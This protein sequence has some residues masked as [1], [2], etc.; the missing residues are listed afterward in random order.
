MSVDPQSYMI[1]NDTQIK[2]FFGPYRWM[3]NFHEC[4]VQF[5]GDI[6]PSSEHAYQAAKYDSKQRTPFFAGTMQI[7][8]VRSKKLGA[9]AELD[10][11][12]WDERRL[13]VM[14][15]IVFSKFL[16]HLHLR[17]QLKATKGKYLEETNHWGDCYWGVCDGIGDNML[18][19][20]LMATR[21]YFLQMEE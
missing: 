16:L 21:A 20:I 14:Q 3:S 1:H 7:S 2:G 5:E 12:E 15:D 10:P 8:P 17:E 6:Y 19:K 9:K 13:R 18:G 11:N 4:L